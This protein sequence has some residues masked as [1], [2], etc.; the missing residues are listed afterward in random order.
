MN[1]NWLATFEAL[2]TFGAAEAVALARNSLEASWVS[3]AQKIRW[4]ERVAETVALAS[5]Y[6][7]QK[8]I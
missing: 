8:S 6:A 1:A 5:R 2:P 4:L 7:G 3:E